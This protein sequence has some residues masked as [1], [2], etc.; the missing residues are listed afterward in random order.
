M[1]GQRR[2]AR[3]W[4]CLKPRGRRFPQ[5]DWPHPRLTGKLATPL[6]IP[7]HANVPTGKSSNTERIVKRERPC[8]DDID[9][10]TYSVRAQERVKSPAC[11][12]WAVQTTHSSP[13]FMIEPFPNWPS[14][15]LR[16]ISSA[17]RRS[18]RV[19]CKHLCV[20]AVGHN[21]GRNGTSPSALALL[22]TP[23][24]DFFFAKVR[25]APHTSEVHDAAELPSKELP[26]KLRLGAG[27]HTL[28]SCAWRRPT[29]RDVHDARPRLAWAML[30]CIITHA[31]TQAQAS[32][33]ALWKQPE[34][35]GEAAELPWL[36]KQ[37]HMYFIERL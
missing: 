3:V 1:L 21:A 30:D 7:I 15:C 14:T 24:R 5:R 25:D 13:S 4:S 17:R 12:M 33:D 6:S 32:T 22:S 18:G 34:H 20:S 36:S 28:S 35:R 8:G 9:I 16:A 37:K 19:R 31:H 26:S 23:P 2:V 10:C 11:G 29:S 27:A